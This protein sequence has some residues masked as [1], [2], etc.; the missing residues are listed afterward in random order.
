MRALITA[1]RAIRPV[2]RVFVFGALDQSRW[3]ASTKKN[4]HT[5]IRISITVCSTRFLRALWA[6]AARTTAA[7][8]CGHRGK[9]LVDALHAASQGEHK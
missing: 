2:F 9:S 4:P 7:V 8:R 1:D 5:I 3:N 6:R